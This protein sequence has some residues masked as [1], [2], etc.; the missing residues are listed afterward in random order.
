MQL[1]HCLRGHNYTHQAITKTLARVL[2]HRWACTVAATPKPAPASAK[3]CRSDKRW[4]QGFPEG[5]QVLPQYELC[6]V[7]VLGIIVMASRRILI[8]VYLGFGSCYTTPSRDPTKEHS[9]CC[10]SCG[11]NSL[12]LPELR[13]SPWHAVNSL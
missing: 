5:L 1:Y 8:F 4:E 9:K 3:T 7:P 12:F 6:S 11:I 10:G 2:P 13:A